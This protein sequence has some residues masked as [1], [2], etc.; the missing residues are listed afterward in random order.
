MKICH[1]KG[2]HDIRIVMCSNISRHWEL[3]LQK[4]F[5][6]AFFSNSRL[7][8]REVK[9][10]SVR[11]LSGYLGWNLYRYKYGKKENLDV[12]PLSVENVALLTCNFT[13]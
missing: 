13:S 6:G 1:D 7:D 11:T 2:C 4:S 3:F 9:T 8:V 5:T 12:W 10:E